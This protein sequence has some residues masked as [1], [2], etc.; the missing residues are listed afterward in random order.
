LKALKEYI[1]DGLA[2]GYIE[3]TNSPYASPLFFQEKSD[4][5][6]HPIVDYRALNAWTVRDVYPLPLI[7][8]I[9]NHLQGKTLFTK[10]DLRWGF[11]NILIKEEDQWKAVFKTPFSMHK[12]K[13]M[14]FGLSNAPSTFCRA[15]NCIFRTLTDWYPTELF[16]YVDDIL[17]ATNEGINRHCQIIGEV[18]HLLAR[19]S[20][21]LRPAKCNFEQRSITYLGVIV[22]NNTI[23]PDP[24]KTSALKDWPHQLST[25]QEV[26]S[27][28]GV[29]GYQRPFIPN[30][31]NIAKPL[32]ALT[33]KDHPFSWTKECETALNTLITI[34]LDNPSLRQPD[35][36]RPFFLQVDTSVFTTGAI[37]TQK[38]ERGKHVAM[39]F[40]SQTFNDAERNY[41]IHDHK[42]LAV[43]RGLAHHR[44]LLLSSPFPTTVFTDHKNLEY[45]RHP[46]HINRRVARY[47]PQLA[48]YDFK[49]VHFPGTANKADALSRQPDY[50]KGNDDNE[51]IIVLPPHLFARATTFSNINDRA[52]ACQLQ[53]PNLLKQWANTFPLKTIG[54]L[55][56]HSDRLVVMDDLPLRRGVISLYHNSPTAGHPGISNTTWAIAQ[57][58]WWPNMKQTVSEYV[59]GCHLCQSHKN[60]PT[61]PKPP[62]FPIPSDKFTL[63][64]TS[65]AMDFIVKLPTSHGY[66]SILTITDTFSKACIFIPCNETID[67]VG[68]ALLY[69]TYVLPHYRLPSRIISDRD[70]CFM[71]SVIQELFR[72]L[73]IQHNQSTAYHPQTDGQSERSSQ[74][75]E[76]YTRIFTDYHQTNWSH[77]L[78]LAQ[79][80]FNAWP[81]TV[82]DDSSLRQAKD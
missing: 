20:Y 41:D 56:W 34:I 38:D 81:N 2:K 8:S 50:N 65:I 61:K 15:M 26:R 14:P 78:P 76:Q 54:D 53:Q 42:F 37:L 60:N 43:F 10:M 45:Y 33:K 7:S 48:D 40:Q 62:P 74:K 77:L 71:A 52:L 59:K 22:E 1:D 44:Q 5:K 63:P 39:G 47:I 12:T 17:V 75:L 28:L 64:F 69:A 25:V 18:L 9:I 57:D 30:F 58:Y 27:I 19:E 70:P 3:E 36:S 67:A 31:T 72:S 24:K 32:V 68:T 21:F 16:V 23:R 55:Y 82:A 46:H 51:D 66:D 13:V 35:L 49:L 73:S 79:F 6:L 29:L 80:A 11:N 4:S